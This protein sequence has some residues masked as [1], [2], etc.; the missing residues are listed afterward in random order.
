MKKAQREKG[1]RRCPG[2]DVVVSHQGPEG[3]P[4][5]GILQPGHVGG[6]GLD[7]VSKC[8]SET[9]KPAHSLTSQRL[10]RRGVRFRSGSRVRGSRV[11]CFVF[12][13]RVRD[14]K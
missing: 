12:V 5:A 1:T 6:E 8:P 3:I 10:V 13:M 4:V 2:R 9:E 11:A 14:L 7:T